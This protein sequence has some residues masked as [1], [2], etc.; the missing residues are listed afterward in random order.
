[1]CDDEWKIELT[2]EELEDIRSRAIAL[3]KETVRLQQEYVDSITA[4]YEHRE[5]ILSAF[6]KT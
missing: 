3:H 4:N 6:K 1:M 5:N 2:E